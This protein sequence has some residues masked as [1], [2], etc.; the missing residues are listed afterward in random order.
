MS[1]TTRRYPIVVGLVL[2]L[3]LAL[4]CVFGRGEPVRVGEV[5]GTGE[6]E[7]RVGEL[8]RS[9]LLHVPTA[10]PRRLGRELNYPLV[11]VLHGSGASGETVRRMSGMDTLSDSMHFV[12]AYPNGSTGRLHL[13]SDWNAGA[14]CGPAESRNVDDVAFIRRLIDT[15]AATVPIDRNRIFVAGFSDGGRMTFR[16][17][18]EMSGTVA[19]IAVVSGSIADSL[20][21]PKR[22]VP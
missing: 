6:H 14:C 21:A 13:R 18:C 3:L 20:C 8:E 10:R 4:G 22:A 9:Y 19:A 7:V 2:P 15:V 12:V 16:V 5:A 1:Y 11:I 17:A